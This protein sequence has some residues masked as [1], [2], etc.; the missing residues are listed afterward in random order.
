[1]VY[2]PTEASTKDHP[3]ESF[4]LGMSLSYYDGKG[5]SEILVYKGASPD[6]LSCTIWIQDG[7]R[8]VVYDSH[9]GLKLQPDISNIPSTPM[10]FINEVNVGISKLDPQTLATSCI[11]TTIQH[12]IM[13]WH[14]RMYH[15]SFPKIFR[16]AEL[17]HIPR[18]LLNCKKNA[19]LCVAC[20][21]GTAHSRP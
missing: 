17:V 15:L 8:V 19:P 3:S 7:T 18:R 16:L 6:D 21:F 12:E 2:A 11:I 20:Q 1:M 13:G 10:A 9:L 5:K 4:E 14:H